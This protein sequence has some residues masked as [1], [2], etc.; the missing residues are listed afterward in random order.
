M[1]SIERSAGPATVVTGTGSGRASDYDPDDMFGIRRALL[2]LPETARDRFFDRWIVLTEL[3][4]FDVVRIHAAVGTELAA[5]ADPAEVLAR[6]WATVEGAMAGY[7][8]W[9]ARR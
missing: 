2:A 9:R 6:A 5:Q 1:R 4:E 3:A 8:D 7:L